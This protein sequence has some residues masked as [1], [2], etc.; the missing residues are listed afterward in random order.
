[1]TAEAARKPEV[2]RVGLG[3][4]FTSPFNLT[5]HPALAL[6]AGI[7]A[8]TGLPIGLQLIGALDADAT[9]LQLGHAF[10]L[11]RPRSNHA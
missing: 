7:S 1:V 5:G 8:S 11:S 6:P 2:H 10:E 4:A 3:A 9:L